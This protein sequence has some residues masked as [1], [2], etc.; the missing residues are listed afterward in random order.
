MV[1]RHSHTSSALWVSPE[2]GS[3]R[4]PIPI[5]SSFLFFLPPRVLFRSAPEAIIKWGLEVVPRERH[6]CDIVMRL[7]GSL[8]PFGG[9]LSCYH[10][11]TILTC[12]MGN[13]PEKREKKGLLY[14]SA[15]WRIHPPPSL[16]LFLFFFP[17][18]LF[19]EKRKKK[20]R[21]MNPRW[22]TSAV[23]GRDQK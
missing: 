13:G 22:H 19:P 8:R 16:L 7:L 23:Y 10:E 21:C 2:T 11:D 5:L 3:C 18:F 15:T 20:Q 4:V 17:S 14:C 6:Q 12:D 1:M 9:I